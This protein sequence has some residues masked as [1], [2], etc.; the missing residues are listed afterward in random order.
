MLTAIV[1]DKSCI[2][3]PAHVGDVGFDVIASSGPEFVRGQDGGILYVQYDTSLRIKPPSGHFCLVFP[4]SSISNY[5]LMLANS[6]GVIDEGYRGNIMIRFKPMP[7]LEDSMPEYYK[8]GD[9]IAQLIFM[10]AV[11]PTLIEGDVDETERA[12]KGFGSS[13]Q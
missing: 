6:V 10:P 3:N 5:D 11:V 4:R 13:G 2:N 9:K 8:K 7:C 12:G 1:S